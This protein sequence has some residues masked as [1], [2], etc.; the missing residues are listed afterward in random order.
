MKKIS[1]SQIASSSLARAA[2][3]LIFFVLSAIAAELFIY[4]ADSRS[5]VPGLAIIFVSIIFGLLLIGER[6]LLSRV[7]T[8]ATLLILSTIALKFGHTPIS[9]I[10][11]LVIVV[12]TAYLGALPLFHAKPHTKRQAI[13]SSVTIAAV[14]LI[15]VALFTYIST[16]LIRLATS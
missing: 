2:S 3:F 14:A 16:V 4:A 10:V 6:H 8:A 9:S 5:I 13:I 15:F 7:T 1:L 12:G 11:L